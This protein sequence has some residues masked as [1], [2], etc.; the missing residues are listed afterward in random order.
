M[1]GL[2]GAALGIVLLVDGLL[3]LA[4]RRTEP[5]V[6]LLHPVAPPLTR[7]DALGDHP[8]ADGVPIPPDALRRAVER[9]VSAVGD[10]DQKALLGEIRAVEAG[11]APR[12]GRA[13]ELRQ[14]VVGDAVALAEVVGPERLAAIA[15]AREVLARSVGETAVWAEVDAM[16]AGGRGPSAEDRTVLPPAPG[17]PLAPG[18]K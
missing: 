12:R 6:M 5:A 16:L 11:F 3:L 18:V 13:G 2:R 17:E 7:L 10:E 8:L 4:L 15:G 14:R 9:V 1:T